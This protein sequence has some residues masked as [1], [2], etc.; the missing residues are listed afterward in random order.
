MAKKRGSYVQ[1]I[2]ILWIKELNMDEKVIINFGKPFKTDN[3]SYDEALEKYLE[4][5]EVS[6]RENKEKR[7]ELL[8]EKN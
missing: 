5:Q 6:M 2:T 1:P 7:S 3:M 4:I 8:M